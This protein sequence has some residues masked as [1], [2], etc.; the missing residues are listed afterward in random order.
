MQCRH[1][2]VLIYQ[3]F[4]YTVS[5]YISIVKR[6]IQQFTINEEWFVLEKAMTDVDK[7]GS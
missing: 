7:G 4:K 2:K 1:N 5:M 6:G 3:Y